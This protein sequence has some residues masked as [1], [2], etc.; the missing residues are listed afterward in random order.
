MGEKKEFKKIFSFLLKEYPGKTLTSFKLLAY[1]L[2][3]FLPGRVTHSVAKR[4][5]KK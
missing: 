5:M 1:R 4:I 3:L 2:L